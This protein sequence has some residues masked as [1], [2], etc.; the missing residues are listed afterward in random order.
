MAIEKKIPGPVA[1][2]RVFSFL[3]I[4]L[5]TYHST[6]HNTV[7]IDLNTGAKMEKPNRRPNKPI[8]TRIPVEL[9]NALDRYIESTRPTPTKTSVLIYA[10][11][12]LLVAR[13]FYKSKNGAK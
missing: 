5:N 4:R 3:L 1:G 10:L 6:G 8:M 7:D 9:G 2:L 11:E 13:G 12:E